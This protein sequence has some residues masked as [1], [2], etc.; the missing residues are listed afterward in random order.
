MPEQWRP[1]PGHEG[2]Y[3]VSD[4]G[5][6]RSWAKWRRRGIPCPH[7]LDGATDEKGYRKVSLCSGGRQRTFAVHRLVAVA[8]LGPLPAGLQ[9]R[10][11]DGDPGNNALSNLRYG[12]PSENQQDSIQHGTMRNGNTDKT[13]CD[14]GHPFDEANT[15]LA[16]D[17]KRDCRACRAERMRT[18]WAT[19]PD[20]KREYMRAWRARKRQAAAAP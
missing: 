12:T 13:H 18:F 5:R 9:T 7:I 15:Y 6:V 1:I 8:F 17:G 20:Y 14:A 16:S 19:N 2:L 11:L 3:E 4:L 10:H